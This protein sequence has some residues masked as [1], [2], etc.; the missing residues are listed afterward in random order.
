MTNN[1]KTRRTLFVR[2]QLTIPHAYSVGGINLLP[3][4]A[5]VRLPCGLGVEPCIRPNRTSYTSAEDVR[6]D[7]GCAWLGLQVIILGCPSIASYIFPGEHVATCQATREN[8]LD[9]HD[10]AQ[11]ARCVGQSPTRMDIAPHCN[12]VDSVVRTMPWNRTNPHY[13][14][15]TPGS[16][17]DSC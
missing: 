1:I 16:S 10:L 7:L 5:F 4:T 11:S 9:E 17:V 14:G 8:A 15:I 3:A 13:S 6:Y 12:I 2:L